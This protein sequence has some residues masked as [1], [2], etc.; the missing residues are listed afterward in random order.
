[1]SPDGTAAGAIS[2]LSVP[3][4]RLRVTGGGSSHVLSIHVASPIAFSHGY[5]AALR[6]NVVV[7]ASNDAGCRPGSKGTLLVSTPY[8]SSPTVKLALCGHSY[9]D[10][11]GSV[12]AF[13]KNV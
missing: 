5:G 4:F 8:L 3:D 13:I 1:V 10:G 12:T 6:S 11:K 7:V 2:N 9:L